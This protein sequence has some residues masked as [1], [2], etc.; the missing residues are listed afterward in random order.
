VAF[1][2]RESYWGLEHLRLR[3]WR[4]LFKI[5][6]DYFISKYTTEK[7][8]PE[9]GDSLAEPQSA[10]FRIPREPEG[11]GTCERCGFVLVE[12]NIDGWQIQMCSALPPVHLDSP[13]F[14]QWLA[15]LANRDCQLHRP[16]PILH[17]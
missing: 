8:P 6:A 12:A 7:N 5:P 9:T 13:K 11:Y 17:E 4:Q 15:T 3:L 14:R 2:I 16:E 10:L 1:N